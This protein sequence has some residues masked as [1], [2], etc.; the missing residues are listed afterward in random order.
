[1]NPCK[2][3]GPELFMGTQH[4]NFVDDTKYLGV[5]FSCKKLNHKYVLRLLRL[6]YAKSN[7]LLRVFHEC[8]YGVKLALFCSYCYSAVQNCK[9][10]TANAK[11]Q[12]QTCKCKTAS[13]KLQVQCML[14]KI[15]AI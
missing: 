6:L 11:L 10:K 3:A 1:M 5:T 15:L 14:I 13:A 2:L 9:C 7:R 8:S 4:L 12:V